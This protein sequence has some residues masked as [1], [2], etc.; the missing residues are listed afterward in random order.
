MALLGSFFDP[1]LP[2]LIGVVVYITTKGFFDVALDIR[3]EIGKLCVNAMQ[4]SPALLGTEDTTPPLRSDPEFA[5]KIMDQV[6]VI[7]TEM[8]KLPAKVHSALALFRLLP[9]RR[10]VHAGIMRMARLVEP[11]SKLTTYDER[12]R[13]YLAILGLLQIESGIN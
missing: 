13:E 3:H 2:I 7:R 9:R 12:H 1:L 4:E 5:L 11:D 6:F 8:T 10:E